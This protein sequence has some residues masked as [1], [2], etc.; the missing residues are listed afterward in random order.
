[1]VIPAR[2]HRIV[3][4]F[5]AAALMLTLAPAAYAA[6]VKAEHM[7]AELVAQGEAVPGGETYVAFDQ[8]MEPGWHTYWRNSGDAGMPTTLTWTLPPGWKAGDIVWP[9]PSQLPVGPLMNYGFEN[10]VLLP[11]AITAPANAKAGE[12]VTLKA[13]MDFLICS[14]ICVPGTANLTLDLKIAAAAAPAA[15]PVWAGKITDVLAAAPKPGD[16]KAAATRDA[17]GI[18]LSLTGDAIKGGDFPDAYFYPYDGGVMDYAKPQPIE[19]G[20]DGLTLTLAPAPGVPPA[21]GP[22]KGVLVAGPGK[23]YEIEATD[24]PPLAGASGLGLP[25]AA[26]AKAGAGSATP[27]GGLTLVSAILFAFVGGLILNLMPCVFPVLS[28]KAAALARHAHDPSTARKEGLAFLAG[29]LATFLILAGALIA[30]KAGGA[31]VGWGFQLQSPPV[32]AALCLLM[33]LVALNLSGLFE[34]GLSAQGAGT[35]L[36]SQSGL[37]GAFFTGALAVVVAAPCTAPFMATALGYAVAQPPA[38]S[39]LIFASL[40]LG[41]AAPFVLIAFAPA[42]LA[43]L[44]KPGAWM[45]VFKTVL[46]FPMYGAAAWLAWVFVVQAGDTALPFLFGAGIVIALGAWLFGLGQKSFE[47][48]KKI[49]LQLALPV[50]LVASAIALAPVAKSAPAAP[51]PGGAVQAVGAALPAVAWTPEKLADLRAQK[52]VVLVD[53]TAAWCVTCQVNERTSLA[54]KGVADA[55]AKAGAV[56][57]KADWTNRDAVIAKELSDHG[58]AGVPLYLMYPANGGAPKELPQ[59]LTEGLVKQAVED[60]SKS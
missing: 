13:K 34:I 45:E 21:T 20:P 2:I 49:A 29:V 37:V 28:M 11:V 31:A 54:S 5:V 24:G 8:K 43:R 36:A 44:P 33:L 26:K 3:Q 35:S 38:L 9:A 41:F 17:S 55:F 6:P 30:A 59:L 12:V 23:A 22:V 14:N 27:A 42:L 53:F 32:V 57:M 52:K 48:P 47:T 1:M 51:A 50:A 58:R 10:E 4:V 19:R 56:Y 25:K 60:A 46:S 15:D 39:L 16:L 40:G 7:T 18:K